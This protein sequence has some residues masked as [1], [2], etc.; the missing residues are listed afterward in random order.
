MVQP[1][2]FEIWLWWVIL[3]MDLILNSQC[4]II[5]RTCLVGSDMALLQLSVKAAHISCKVGVRLK[6]HKLT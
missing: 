5:C 1:V 4:H 3:K 2:G 6:A